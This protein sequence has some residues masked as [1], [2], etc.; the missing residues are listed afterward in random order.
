MFPSIQ[1]WVVS[2]HQQEI[3]NIDTT[4]PRSMHCKHTSG[5][6]FS[7]SSGH[8]ICAPSEFCRPNNFKNLEQVL[9]DNS[10]HSRHYFKQGCL[11]DFTG[12]GKFSMPMHTACTQGWFY[13]KPCHRGKYPLSFLFAGGS[14]PTSESS[15]NSTVS[16]VGV[17]LKSTDC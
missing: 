12:E 17:R 5:S 1:K 6:S 7:S 3:I 10:V 11:Y 4:I 9:Y 8:S 16:L 2:N 13:K 14:L 15:V